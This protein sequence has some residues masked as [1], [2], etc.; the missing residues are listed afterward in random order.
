[1]S[2]FDAAVVAGVF[3]AVVAVWGVGELV[4]VH[5]FGVL[6]VVLRG[7]ALIGAQVLLLGQ[8]LVAGQLQG[9]VGVRGVGVGVLA[10][11]GTEL[12]DVVVGLAFRVRGAGLCPVRGHGE[13][14][15]NAKVLPTLG[16]AWMRWPSTSRS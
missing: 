7:R 6:L 3:G 9:G 1:M 12:D 15:G 4:V 2:A 5:W 16:S 14:S 13:I 8:V 10:Q 11:L